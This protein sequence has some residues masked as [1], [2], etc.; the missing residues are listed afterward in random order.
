M[1]LSLKIAASVGVGSSAI[2]LVMSALSL[3]RDLAIVEEDLARD[4]RLVAVS[5]ATAV[6]GLSAEEARKHV[7]RVDAQSDEIRVRF[8]PGS[9]EDGV[10]RD[11]DA[12]RATVRTDA[13]AVE[14]SESLAIRDRLLAGSLSSLFATAVFIMLVSLAAGH[15]VGRLVV[16]RRVDLLI[17]KAQRVAQGRFDELVDIHGSDELDLLGIELNLMAGQLEDARDTA[18]A[19]AEA[20]LQAEV[21]LQHADRLRTVGQIAAGMAHELGTPLNVISGRATLLTRSA[22]PGSSQ[23]DGALAIQTQAE[24]ITSIVRRLMDYSRPTPLRRQTF[25]LASLVGETV[26][27]VHP[28]AASAHV[29]L[30]LACAEE[31]VVSADAEQLRQVAANLI[32]NAIQATPD[33][34]VRVTLRQHDEAVLTVEDDGPGVPAEDRE[35]VLEPFFT[36]KEPGMGT[37]LGLAI[38]RTIVADHAGALTVSDSELGGACFT[39]TLPLETECPV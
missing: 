39:V 7:A 13:G 5:V 23:H 19:E 17:D 32:M 26:E 25:D 21:G 18:A 22:E 31:A 9:A 36:T 35:R 10:T 37:G 16:G 11:D 12:I 4:A 8:L 14:V 28:A 3:Q 24:R 15:W 27:L 20:R 38:A 34:R 1:R 29:D 33:G 2:V 30:E 6:E